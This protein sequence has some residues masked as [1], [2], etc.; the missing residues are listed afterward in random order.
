[1][2]KD[3]EIMKALRYLLMVMIVA[4]A[5]VTAQAQLTT[6]FKNSQNQPAFSTQQVT[7][8][9]AVY[10]TSTLMESGSSLPIAAR[11]GVTIEAT[12]PYDD[13]PAYVPGRRPKRD[14]GGGEVSDDDD[15]EPDD[16]EEPYPLGDGVWVLL[17]MALGYAAYRKR[18]MMH[19]ESMA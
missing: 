14:V 15:E 6:P 19:A 17:L 1:M 4:L 9:Y 12:T 16:P 8:T 10:T 5:S 18:K 3:L 2:F 11:N 7:T 13:T